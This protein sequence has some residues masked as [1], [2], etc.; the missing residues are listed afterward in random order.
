MAEAV[1]VKMD[2]SGSDRA[3][4]TPTVAIVLTPVTP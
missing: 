4:I 1:I 3:S 2:G